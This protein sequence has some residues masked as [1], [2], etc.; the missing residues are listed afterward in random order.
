MK[1]GPIEDLDAWA[2]EAKEKI[3][4][5]PV[6]ASISGGK[7]ST[8]MALLLRA[9]EIPFTSINLDTG[10]EHEDTDQYVRETLPKYIGPIKTLCAEIE[11]KPEVKND[12]ERFEAKLG[13]TSA[14]IRTIL[15][16]GIFPSKIRRFCTRK[17][18]VE[19]SAKFLESLD[20]E[21]VMVTG[22]R[23]SE[24]KLR[25]TYPE[26]ERWESGGCDQWRPLLRWSD[27]DVVDIHRMFEI[28]PN[29]LY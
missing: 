21:P 23:A 29:P 15:N 9:A 5:R 7:D 24:S 25:S 3:D 11:P 18:K 22:I 27:Q 20:D 14:M 13:R 28:P 2:A 26:W 6:I 4:G 12:I 1:L 10:W 17:I 16:N 8:A 19:V